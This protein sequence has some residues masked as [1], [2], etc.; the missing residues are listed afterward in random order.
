[1]TREEAQRY[2]ERYIQPYYTSD[3]RVNLDPAQHA[4]D[5]VAAEL[6]VDVSGRR[7]HLRTSRAPSESDSH[8][9]ERR[10]HSAQISP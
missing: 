10:P 8:G 1:M 6:G 5:A 2:Y 3:G 7:R 9:I 4:V